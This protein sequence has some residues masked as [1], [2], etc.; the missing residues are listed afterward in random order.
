MYEPIL[1]DFLALFSIKCREVIMHKCLPI[2]RSG[3]VTGKTECTEICYKLL[4]TFKCIKV[5]KCECP[6]INVL[7]LETSSC[8]DIKTELPITNHPKFGSLVF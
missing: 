2:R 6:G 4:C 5:I 1:V 3:V 7:S 8:L